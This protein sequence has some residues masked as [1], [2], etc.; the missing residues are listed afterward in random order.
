[1]KIAS[2]AL[3]LESTHAIQQEHQLSE[4]LRMWT[5][6]RRPNFEGSG[7]TRVATQQP[8]PQVQLSD[9]GKTAQ[10]SEADAIQKSLD[11]VDNDPMLSLIKAMVAMLTG[12]EVKVFNSAEL[13]GNATPVDIRPPE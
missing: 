10:S 5:G 2:A 1:M 8:V 6:N 13:Q 7:Q 9:A 11:A 12:H 4:S 3:Q